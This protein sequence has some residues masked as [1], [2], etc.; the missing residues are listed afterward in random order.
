MGLICVKRIITAASN[1][2]KACSELLTCKRQ[3][4]KNSDVLQVSTFKICGEPDVSRCT[5]QIQC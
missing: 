1:K 4:I 5:H 3:V 2:T